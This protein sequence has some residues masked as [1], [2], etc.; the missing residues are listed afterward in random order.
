MK[1]ILLMAAVVFAAT[2]TGASAQ[3]FGYVNSQEVVFALPDV[4]D[5]EANLQ[6]MGEEWMLQIEEM[7]VEGNKKVDEY[8]KTEATLSEVMKQQKQAEIQGLSQRIDELRTQAQSEMDAKETELMKPL[9]DKVRVAIE[10]VMKAQ[11][12]A[13]VFEGGA[14]VTTDPAQ[15]TDVTPLVKKQ[16]GV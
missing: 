5:V 11:G 1:K 15:M 13:G 9:I 4:K 12:L 8:Q 6:K 16:L 7:T 14:L 2:A 3:K 10:T